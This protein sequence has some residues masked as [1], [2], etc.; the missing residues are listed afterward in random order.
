MTALRHIQ[1]V[2]IA[3]LKPQP[4][5]EMGPAPVVEWVDPTDLSIETAYQRD[6]SE[7]SL[8]MIRRII[9]SEWS[10]DRFKPPVCSRL[11]DGVLVVVDGQHTAIAAASHPGIDRIPVFIVA[12]SAAAG[13]ADAFVG[14]NRDRLAITRTQMHRAAVAAG[15]DTAV[16]LD[17][18]C[19]A[20]GVTLL[21]ISRQRGEWKA[22]ETIAVTALLR[23]VTAKGRAGAARVLR[24]LVEAG[25][26]PISTLLIR[27]V[28]D[29]LYQPEWRVTDDA[30][31]SR[32]IRG[33]TAEAWERWAA[34]NKVQGQTASRTVAVELFRRLPSSR[35]TG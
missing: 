33:N 16:A 21:S 10:W 19:R 22:G 6:L 28:F 30:E 2:S 27:A 9:L 5:E 35:E 15:D 25:Q 8:R 31:L 7:R 4:V 24:I 26:R 3:G 12:S 1:P 29:L 32:A 13:R 17:E 23:V 18:A 14:H 20:A 34:D 11:E